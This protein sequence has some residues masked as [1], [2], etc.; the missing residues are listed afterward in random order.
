MR[1]ANRVAYLA[2]AGTVM[3]WAAA[4]PAITVAVAGLGVL[5]LS[6]LRLFCRVGGAGRR[7]RPGNVSR[8]G[9]ATARSV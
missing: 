3:L 9:E 7:G 2:A 4:F 5:G 6:V 1:S 8:G